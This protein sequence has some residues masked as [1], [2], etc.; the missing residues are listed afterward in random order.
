M[1]LWL[2]GLAITVLLG[3]AGYAAY[4]L[5]L[6]WKQK[7]EQ[8]QQ[9]KQNQLKIKQIRQE[10]IESLRIIAAAMCAE[11]CEVAEGTIRIVYLL[12]KSPHDALTKVNY[13]TLYELYEKI[14]HQPIGAS[15]K[16]YKRQEIMRFDIERMALE[17][18][19][20][21][22]ILPEVEALKSLC[23]SIQSETV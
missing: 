14:K 1:N 22:R 18:T 5:C 6:L 2:V 13:P 9:E 7:K 20:Q 19:Y 11:Q 21:D 3:L 15:R 12:Q 23:I 8:L 16:H 4:L 10:Q 17:A